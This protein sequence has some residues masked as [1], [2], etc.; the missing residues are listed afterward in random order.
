MGCFHYSHFHPNR[1]EKLLAFL[2]LFFLFG[3]SKPSVTLVVSENAGERVLYGA[4]RL[5]EALIRAGYP[6]SRTGMVPDVAQSKVIVVGRHGDFEHNDFTEKIEVPERKEAFAIQS[7]DGFLTALVG[8]DDSGAL[9][10]CLE[11]AR[12]IDRKQKLPRSVA[13]TDQPE[14]VL[15]GTCI[16]LQK[17]SYLPGRQVYEYPYTPENFP[18]FYDKNLW[19]RYLDMMVENRYN[20][21]YLWNGHPFA[22]L[23]KLPDYPFAVEVDDETFQKNEAIFAFLTE[24]ANKR[25]IW[26]IQMFYNIIVSKPFADHYGIETQERS[27]PILPFIADYTRKSIAE[28]VKKYPNVGLMVCLG[29]A[30]NTIDDDVAW[31]TETIIPGVQ[32]GMKALGL[33]QEPPIVLRGHD[34]DAEKVMNAALPLYKNLYTMYKYNGESLTTYEPR[35][36][37]SEIPTALSRLGSV[38]IAN[39]HI[40][41]NLEPFRWS[42]PDFVQKCVKAMHEHQG[43]NGLHL[44]PQASYWDW[45][46]SADKTE[47]RTLQIDRDGM[48]YQAWAR[49]AW[50]VDRDEKEEDR[51]W[52]ENLATR[53]GCDKKTGALIQK[54]FEETGEI[55]PKL[56]RAF[57]ISDGNR[58]TLLLGNF[59]SQLVNPRKWTLHQ[60]FVESSGPEKELLID[61]VRKEANGES[62]SGE[63]PP[64]IISE[65]VKHGAEALAAMEKAS[66]NI[67]ANTDEFN[68]LFNDIRCYNQVAL[69]FA[70]K[71]RAAEFVLNYKYSNNPVD[72]EKAVP[73]LEKSL[74]YYRELTRLTTDTYLYA[75]SMQTQQ[76]R[77]PIAGT[78]GKY[79]HWKELLPLYEIERENF[80]SNIEKLKANGGIQDNSIKEVFEPVEVK[81]MNKNVARFPLAK[82]AKVNT[83]Q[84]YTVNEVA[85]ALQKL[86]GVA[87]PEEEQ[88]GKG[89]VLKFSCDKPVKVVVGYYNG[90][91]L[92]LLPPPTLETNA[93]ANDRGQADIRIANAMT[94]QGLYPVNVYT[95]SYEAGTHELML[96][97]GRVLIL[98]FIDGKQEMKT[99]DAGITNDKDGV[100]IDWLFY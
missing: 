24:E 98:G 81:I 2:V 85:P 20:S 84:D 54:A 10:A 31:F 93:Q 82:G 30:M 48:W 21:L 53:F 70:E 100:P 52:A 88:R 55:A 38:H 43:A 71:V 25:G 19:I 79:I 36:Q 92:T 49:Y 4:E 60:S 73:H 34:T 33:E 75:N 28:F 86:S 58:Q 97:K 91:S 45:P 40:L 65:V 1:W 3:C 87:F 50:K 61:Y 6:V 5:N 39:V 80:K 74:A 16:G 22:S 27:R 66:K 64:Q 26:V 59:M 62:H 77:V 14:M 32:D 23:V 96:G 57:G 13:R 83:D 17:T 99:Y 12:L 8:N 46:Y 90:N 51:Y 9:Y 35:A 29:E 18:W 37:W 63:T 94:V 76:R 89:T 68:R 44:Y 69:F 56:S 41:A 95:Y 15:R 11:L 7:F 78:D 67:A 47:P 42:S 72:L